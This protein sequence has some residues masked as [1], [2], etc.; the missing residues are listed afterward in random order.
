MTKGVSKLRSV[1]V[2]HLVMIASLLPFLYSDIDSLVSDSPPFHRLL[3]PISL[4]LLFFCSLPLSYLMYY[5]GMGNLFTRA[6]PALIL[7]ALIAALMNEGNLE[8]HTLTKVLVII[9]SIGVV[10]LL[11]SLRTVKGS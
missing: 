10:S 2:L 3:F 4:A 11:L 1:Q 9:E 7:F 6:L 8:M 5:S